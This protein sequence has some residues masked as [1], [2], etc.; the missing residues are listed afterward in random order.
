MRVWWTRYPAWRIG[1]TVRLPAEQHSIV[2]A[3]MGDLIQL[4]RSFGMKYVKGEWIKRQPEELSDLPRRSPR[5]WE[6]MQ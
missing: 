6:A 3:H 1:I 4:F 2:A 5:P